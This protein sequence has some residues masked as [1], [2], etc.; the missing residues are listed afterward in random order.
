VSVLPI[1]HKAGFVIVYCL[2][3]SYELVY[4]QPNYTRTRM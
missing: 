2:A 4:H 3:T 1:R